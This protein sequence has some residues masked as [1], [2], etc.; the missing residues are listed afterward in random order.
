VLEEG[1]AEWVD[2]ARLPESE[3][4][5]VA[6]IRALLDGEHEGG[7]PYAPPILRLGRLVLA[8]T[9]AISELAADR[10]GLAPSSPEDRLLARQHG[11]TVA[12]V[13]AETHDCHHPI[14]GSLYYEDQREESKR[15]AE[16][17]RNER[18]P[19]FLGHFE[20]V[21]E[22]GGGTWL[23]GDDL[24][25]ADLHLFQLLE[26]LAYAFPRAFERSTEE[27]PRLLALRE[28]VRVRPRIDAYL[29]SERRLAFNEDGI[30]RHYPELDDPD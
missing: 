12:D 29:R 18:V 13:V 21:L 16:H 5:G 27:R 1:G 30:F 23:V 22:R 14:A 8:Q 11:L 2:V 20:S 19:R 15:R 7:L 6:A 10:L 25:W 26:G 28:R 24:C 4:G 17:F 9:V 3:G